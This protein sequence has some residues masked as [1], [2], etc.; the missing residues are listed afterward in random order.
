MF[1]N[2]SMT[3]VWFVYVECCSCND[4]RASKRCVFLDL[5]C[6]LVFAKVTAIVCGA[7]V[8]RR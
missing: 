5:A 4:G 8:P 1:V 7:L 2:T 6:L 3:V